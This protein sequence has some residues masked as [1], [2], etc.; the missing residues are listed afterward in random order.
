MAKR[1]LG[2]SNLKTKQSDWQREF[3]SVTREPDFFQTCSFQRMIENH[4]MFDFRTLRTNISWLNFLLK[5]KNP[6][7]GAF[8]A[9]FAP[10]W[11]NQI[12]PEWKI[13]L[14]HVLT[15]I[16]LYLHAKKSEKSYDP[17]PRKI[18]TDGQHWIHTTSLSWV[19]NK[20]LHEICTMMFVVSCVRSYSMFFELTWYVPRVN[21]RKHGF[22]LFWKHII[23]S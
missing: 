14:C 3:R 16:D 11:Q 22:T 10:N 7:F 12:F 19:H 9:L 13:G 20:T 17:L 21:A 2:Y 18:R 23:P 1:L 15:L 5:C 8:L 4:N 6:I